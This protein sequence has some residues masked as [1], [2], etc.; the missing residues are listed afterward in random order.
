MR[1]RLLRL[2]GISLRTPESLRQEWTIDGRLFR[3]CASTAAAGTP[4]V[5]ARVLDLVELPQAL[6]LLLLAP[7]LPLLARGQLGVV[8]LSGA[9]GLDPRRLLVVAGLPHVG[10]LLV[11]RFKAVQT[12][13][14][15]GNWSLAQRHEIVP[16]DDAGLATPTERHAAARTELLQLRLDEAKRKASGKGAGGRNNP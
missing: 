12:S 1:R 15:D 5:V 11:Q 13:V 10:D 7:L 4:K 2:P 8:A 14:I 6:R 16:P 3:F 9:L